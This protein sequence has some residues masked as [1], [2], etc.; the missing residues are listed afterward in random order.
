MAISTRGRY[1]VRAL[2]AIAKARHPL[3]TAK[4][5]QMEDISLPYLEQIFNRLKRAGLVQAKRGAQGGFDLS[6][7]PAQIS[8]GDVVNTLDGP[9]TFSHCHK[10]GQDEPCGRAEICPSRQFWSELENTV[11]SKLFNTT[12]EDLT[13]IETGLIEKK[14]GT[15]S[16]ANLF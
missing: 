11:N 12:L 1:G 10:P 16:A 9:V 6:R 3:S 2:L 4:I 13:N 8:I 5:S 7:P 14:R 15:S